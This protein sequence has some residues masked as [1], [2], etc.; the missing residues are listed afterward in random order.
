M[1]R[2][3]QWRRFTSA[4]AAAH[5]RAGEGGDLDV[6]LDPLDGP[7]FLQAFKEW[8]SGAHERS[9][10]NALR[11][12]VLDFN[13]ASAVADTF[14]HNIMLVFEMLATLYES[15]DHNE[16]V[17]AI[18]PLID[19]VGFRTLRPF[20]AIYAGRLVRA[21]AALPNLEILDASH[22]FSSDDTLPLLAASILDF[23]SLKFLSITAEGA[24][25]MDRVDLRPLAAAVGGPFASERARALRDH[26]Y[27]RV[28]LEVRQ[29]LEPYLR[30]PP[31]T[32]RGIVVGHRFANLETL[33]AFAEAMR[34][35]ARLD[36]RGSIW[37]TNSWDANAEAIK[38]EGRQLSRRRYVDWREYSG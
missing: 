31:S 16:H 3:K 19:H 25:F 11:G 33:K 12:I 32:L 28:G 1:P 10:E 23:A 5:L 24:N 18:V 35:N 17:S 9:D 30:G 27:A 37:V 34:S 15:D 36:V 20:N 38:E 4:A 29:I 14:V 21:L 6:T 8:A 22:A 2:V 26:L 13:G 7:E